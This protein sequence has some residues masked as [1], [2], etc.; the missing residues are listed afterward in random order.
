MK[1]KEP[2]LH[3][4]KVDSVKMCSLLFTKQENLNLATLQ[5]YAHCQSNDKEVPSCVLAEIM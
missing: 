2:A 5:I 1:K 4:H 3:L